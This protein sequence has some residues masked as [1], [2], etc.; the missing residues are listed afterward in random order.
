MNAARITFCEGGFRLETKQV[1][2]GERAFDLM[3]SDITQITA[4]NGS[5]YGGRWMRIHYGAGS[6]NA[7]FSPSWTN[8]D[9]FRI[10]DSFDA[11][12]RAAGVLLEKEAGFWKGMVRDRWIV[13][14]AP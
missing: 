12:A 11:S 2:R 9:T 7:A 13:R 14:T 8:S 1:F 4:T 10:V 3:W 6:D 5:L